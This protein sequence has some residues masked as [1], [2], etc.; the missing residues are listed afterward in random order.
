[1]WWAPL[2]IIKFSLPIYVYCPGR[3]NVEKY[4][5]LPAGDLRKHSKIV[6]RA[7]VQDKKGSQVFTQEPLPIVRNLPIQ[8]DSAWFRLLVSASALPA[9]RLECRPDWFE[10][11]PES[12]AAVLGLA[13]PVRLL[14]RQ[15]V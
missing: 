5:L 11:R 8:V 15:A 2:D 14:R 1:M 13:V 10:L 12:A 9:S 7:A 3:Q 4:L 6:N